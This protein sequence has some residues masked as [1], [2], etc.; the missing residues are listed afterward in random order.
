[1]LTFRFWAQRPLSQPDLQAIQAYIRQYDPK[2]RVH[3]LKRIKSF[4]EVHI[5]LS[6]YQSNPPADTQQ[7]LTFMH[8]LM[9]STPWLATGLN[10]LG[11]QYPWATRKFTGADDDMLH[12]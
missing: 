8:R 2:A 12:K 11:I 7:T 10:Y 1:M 3:P 9:A 6:D 4:D 5:K